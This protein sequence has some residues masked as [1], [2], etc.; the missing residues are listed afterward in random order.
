MLAEYLKYF[1]K[2]FRKMQLQE[3]IWDAS[4]GWFLRE[5]V[6]EV[7]HD[8]IQDPAIVDVGMNLEDDLPDVGISY[9]MICG[10]DN[11]RYDEKHTDNVDGSVWRSIETGNSC[12]SSAAS[13]S[14]KVS[15]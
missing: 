8:A 5:I 9:G 1:R 2:H 11:P 14:R 4:L 10:T 3:S 13:S 6:N 15:D 7:S 12:R